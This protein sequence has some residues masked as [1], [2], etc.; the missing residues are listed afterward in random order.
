MVS[1]RLMEDYKAGAEEVETHFEENV[2]ALQIEND[3][4]SQDLD[5][6]R[7]QLEA[8][9]HANKDL[10]V[11]VEDVIKKYNTQQKELEI[12]FINLDEKTRLQ[13]ELVHTVVKKLEEDIIMLQ[14]K[15]RIVMKERDYLRDANESKQ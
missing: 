7:G 4:L 9:S 15:L 13:I 6:L 1:G 8:S 5:N 3:A 2:Q 12:E 14:E 10:G 11:S